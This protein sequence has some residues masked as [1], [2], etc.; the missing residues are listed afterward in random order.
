MSKE[1]VRKTKMHHIEHIL[2]EETYGRIK[3][4]VEKI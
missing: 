4:Y 3:E 2:S 1:T